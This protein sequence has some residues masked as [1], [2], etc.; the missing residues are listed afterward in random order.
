MR[1][2]AL[3]GIYAIVLVA[4]IVYAFVELRGPSGIGALMQR[5]ALVSQFEVENQKLNQEL[6]HRQ[7]RIQRLEQ[8]PTEQEFE[9]RQR[10][11]LAK[12]GEKIYILEPGDKK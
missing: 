2:Q 9:I 1:N 10:L 12:P 4:G 3:K 8:N 11:K 7:D 5:R 6:Q